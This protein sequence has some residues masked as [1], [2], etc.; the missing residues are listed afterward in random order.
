[1]ES[2]GVTPDDIKDVAAMRPQLAPRSMEWNDWTDIS[3][4]DCKFIIENVSVGKQDDQS[5]RNGKLKTNEHRR[6]HNWRRSQ[7]VRLFQNQQQSSGRPVKVGT[8]YQIRTV[9]F[10]YTG[11]LVAV[12]PQKSCSLTRRGFPTPGVLQTH[13]LQ[14]TTTK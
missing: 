13:A 1:M 7:A 14:E 6:H 9:T 5:G 12:H 11:R 4:D 3:D 10:T 2:A 8:L